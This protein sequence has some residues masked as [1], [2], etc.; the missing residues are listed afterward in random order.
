ML[1]RN[2][3]YTHVYNSLFKDGPLE[4][5]VAAGLKRKVSRRESIDIGACECGG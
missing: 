4:Q 2:A 1:Q 3:N 5:I